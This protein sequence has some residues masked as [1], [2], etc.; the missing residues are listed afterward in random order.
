MS[1]LVD[2]M[3]GNYE[4]RVKFAKKEFQPIAERLIRS[5]TLGKWLLWIDP[6]GR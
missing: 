6:L 2:L 5:K 4:R 1:P 3:N